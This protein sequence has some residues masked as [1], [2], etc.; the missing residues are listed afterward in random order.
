MNDDM[1]L[2]ERRQLEDYQ[3]L[4]LL[5]QFYLEL[6]LKAFTFALGI[7]GGV[8][9]FVLGKNLSDP[10][11]A[12]FGLLLPAALCTGMGFGFLW[13]LPSSLQLNK[14][15]KTLK[16]SLN[17]SLAPHALNLTATLFG[18]GL[19]LIACGTFLAWLF[20]VIYSGA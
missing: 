5:F 19:L 7:A 8:S 6:T 4:S 12:A 10:H 16:N 20:F 15:L 9:A 13:A 3:R 2:E 18:F 14:A 17:R 11:L 1:P